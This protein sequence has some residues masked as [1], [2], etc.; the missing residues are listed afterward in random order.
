MRVIMPLRKQ[1]LVNRGLKKKRG[2]KYC[3]KFKKLLP[4]RNGQFHKDINPFCFSSIFSKF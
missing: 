2:L 3:A 1:N 4:S